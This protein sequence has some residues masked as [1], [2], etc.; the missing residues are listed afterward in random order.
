[1]TLAIPSQPLTLT[2]A[3]R[4]AILLAVGTMGLNTIPLHAMGLGAAEVRST[5]G[6]SLQVAIPLLTTGAEDN[7]TADCFRLAPP[8][9]GN[10]GDL[11]HLNGGQLKLRHS[12][13]APYLLVTT[14]QPVNDPALS[15]SIATQCNASVRRDYTIL[16]DTP[17]A[18][19]AAQAVKPARVPQTSADEDA[20]PL[21]HLAST[22]T[23]PA[24][25]RTA[26][27]RPRH[28]VRNAPAATPHTQH[29]RLA[30][31]TQS[32]ATLVIE[33]S[34]PRTEAASAQRGGMVLRIS[35]SLAFLPGQHPLTPALLASLKRQQ[36]EL[37]N[38]TADQLDDDITALKMQLTQTRQALAALQASTARQPVVIKPLAAPARPNTLLSS[39]YLL[40]LA[41]LILLTALGLYWLRRNTMHR[42]VDDIVDFRDTTWNELPETPVSVTMPAPI[43]PPIQAHM[44]DAIKDHLAAQVQPAKAEPAWEN[45]QQIIVSSL[46][47]VTEEASVFCTL[48]YPQRAVELL[49]EHI[50]ST[51]VSHPQAWYVLFD[52]YRKH[53]MRDAFDSS[54]TDFKRRFNLVTPTW[55]NTVEEE[56]GPDL[57]SFSHVVERIIQ[58]WPSVPCR[59]YLKGLLYD[60]RGG[61]RQGF[62]MNTYN[63]L[64]FLIELLDN[65]MTEDAPG[66]AQTGS[67][68]RLV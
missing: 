59:N 13:G 29:A 34:A 32:H 46:S 42:R 47:K 31:A 53:N 10:D 36:V 20:A 7:V 1:M 49:Q 66:A 15:F 2:H 11:P 65:E 68:L 28:P 50:A 51:P 27:A 62:S 26:P 44:G 52:I 18:F 14:N 4:L 35:P 6:Q 56:K 30:P 63:D 25:R 37:Q 48:G 21:P 8:Q 12:G 58:L 60:D 5:L 19:S 9:S 45:P 43:A 61:E 67:R 57:Q 24:A 23:Q 22:A 38:N 40:P 55:E 3:K 16:L 41:G 17:T 39:T 33:S 54:L 64:L